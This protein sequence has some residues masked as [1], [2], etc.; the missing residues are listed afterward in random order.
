MISQEATMNVIQRIGMLIGIFV[1]LTGCITQQ[2]ATTLHKDGSGTTEMRIG[3]SQQ[4]LAFASMGGSSAELDAALE[5]LQELGSDL[6]AEW[7]AT[8]EPWESP[9]KDYKGTRITMEFRDLAMLN[10]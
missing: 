3:L 2:T 10:E 1:L 5:Q 7:N 4:M 6:P 8:S 9:D